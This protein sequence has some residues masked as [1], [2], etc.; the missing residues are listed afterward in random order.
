[1]NEFEIHECSYQFP[2]IRVEKSRSYFHEEFTWQLVI[3]REATEKDIEENHYL[4]NIG[5]QLWSVV[6]EINYCPYCGM[7][8][9]EMEHKQKSFALFDSSG[10]SVKCL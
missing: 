8:L 10:W 9:N 1:M 3:E 4:E 7:R 6:A 2:G 5:D